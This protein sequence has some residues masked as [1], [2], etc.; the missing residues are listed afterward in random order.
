LKYDSK[1]GAL[2]PSTTLSSLG[3][4]YDDKY[5][6]LFLKTS[7]SMNQKLFTYDYYLRLYNGTN[8]DRLDITV[9]NGKANYDLMADNSIQS[10]EKILYETM[11]GYLVWKFL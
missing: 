1:T 7:G 2:L 4:T 11:N 3:A 10:N 9:H 5:V 8:F 6:Y